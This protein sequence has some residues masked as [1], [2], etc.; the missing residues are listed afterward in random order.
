MKN[1]GFYNI[2]IDDYVDDA[3]LCARMYQDKTCTINLKKGS[4]L[5]DKSNDP[6]I[7]KA[8]INRANEKLKGSDTNHFK[9]SFDY[10]N[11]RLHFNVRKGGV[12]TSSMSRRTLKADGR[13][14]IIFDSKNDLFIPQNYC[15]GNDILSKFNAMRE[16]AMGFIQIINYKFLTKKQ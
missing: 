16:C 7:I 9:V 11:N 4:K 12:I 2:I 1:Q 8:F 13:T 3:H 15:E 14:E 6:E 10:R 5:I